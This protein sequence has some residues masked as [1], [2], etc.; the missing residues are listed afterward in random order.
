MF[1]RL[2]DPIFL[3]IESKYKASERELQ[4]QKLRLVNAHWNWPL[5]F[6]V[7]HWI[8][9]QIEVDIYVQETL[10]REEFLIEEYQRALE[11]AKD[12]DSVFT[13]EDQNQL[14]RWLM[15][16]ETLNKEYWQYER[17]IYMLGSNNHGGPW[18]RAFKCTR[19]D[20][21]WYLHRWLRRDCAERCGCCGRD[22]G[23]CE[24]PRSLTRSRCFGHCTAA[25]GCCQRARGFEIKRDSEAD[26]L[27]YSTIRGIRQTVQIG[28]AHV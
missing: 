2:L 23:C 15:E 16:L 12:S 4:A 8:V 9:S 7:M 17:Q 18:T 14:Q 24:R 1:K 3:V 27:S 28:R 21:K 19:R 6:E 11:N 13:E 10:Q 25:C 26:E 20:P 5:T 22:C